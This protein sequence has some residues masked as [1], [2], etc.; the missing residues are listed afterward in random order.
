MRAK[1]NTKKILVSLCTIAIALF[2]VAIVSASSPIANNTLIEVDGVNAVTNHPG[3]I[4]GETTAV[5]VTFTALVSA[6]NVVIETELRDN[7]VH[8]DAYSKSFDVE[9]GVTY[10]ETLS[11]EVRSF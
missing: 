1:M 6:T 11:L 7:K 5:K 4:A 2:L 10:H 3:V 8:A 9:A